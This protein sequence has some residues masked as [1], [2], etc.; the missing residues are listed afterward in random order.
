MWRL[1]MWFKTRQH[2]R[3]LRRSFPRVG[4]KIPL[5]EEKLK[6]SVR[7][8]IGN[9]RECPCP[10]EGCGTINEDVLIDAGIIFD[11]PTIERLCLKCRRPVIYL[12][13]WKGYSDNMP[14]RTAVDVTAHASGLNDFR[15]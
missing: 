7:R 3:R 15:A 9:E 2:Y 8:S 13:V 5:L 6:A 11:N 4:D 1:V 12:S 14:R 10:W